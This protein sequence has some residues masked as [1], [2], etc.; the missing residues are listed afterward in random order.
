MSKFSWNR[1]TAH[2]RIALT[3]FA[4]IA[5]IQATAMSLLVVLGMGIAS[6]GTRQYIVTTASLGIVA[7]MLSFWVVFS[8]MGV[9][10]RWVLENDRTAEKTPQEK[11]PKGDGFWIEVPYY[12]DGKTITRGKPIKKIGRPG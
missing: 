11:A 4:V 3:R 6:D 12:D 7:W 5:F 2:H 1:N 8:L 9:M 10:Y